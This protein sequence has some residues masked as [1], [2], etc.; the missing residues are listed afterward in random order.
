M[1]K[2]SVNSVEYAIGFKHQ[3]LDTGTIPGTNLYYHGQT[4]CMIFKGEE[5]VSYGNAWCST[6]DQF[7]KLVGRKV[8]LASAMEGIWGKDE[9]VQVWHAYMESGV[10]YVGR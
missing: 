8:S 4:T 9:R 6:K 2:V 3:P 10:R 1:F 7:S 5:L